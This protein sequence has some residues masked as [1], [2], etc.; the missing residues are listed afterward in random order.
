M[1][2]SVRTNGSAADLYSPTRSMSALR[3]SQSKRFLKK[4]TSARRPR[5]A[6]S[7][8]SGMTIW[9]QDGRHEVIVRRR[10]IEVGDDRFPLLRRCWIACCSSLT[11]AHP[12]VGSLIRR[13]TPLSFSS[14]AALSSRPTI[15]ESVSTGLPNRPVGSAPSGYAAFQL[16]LT[17]ADTAPPST[18]G[19]YRS[20]W[21]RSTR[22]TKRARVPTTRATD[23]D[24]AHEQNLPGQESE[25]ETRTFTRQTASR[26]F[27]LCP[28]HA[29]FHNLRSG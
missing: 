19:L 7:P 2:I 8:D 14:S 5:I 10:R 27:H 4:V 20:G 3:C 22:G 13:M 17:E 25:T 12:S 6:S 15:S 26:R 18:W 28:P 9:S 24:G 1:L 16:D 29:V 23:H 21:P 11:L